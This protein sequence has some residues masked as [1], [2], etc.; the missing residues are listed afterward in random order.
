[1]PK[2]IN[3]LKF[4]MLASLLILM[5]TAESDPAALG[6]ALTLLIMTSALGPRNPLGPFAIGTGLVSLAE[7]YAVTA[8][9]DL[10]QQ[11]EDSL[12]SS[13]DRALVI[14]KT[15]HEYLHNLKVFKTQLDAGRLKIPQAQSRALQKFT[16]ESIASFETL[17]AYH[18]ELLIN[19]QN[20]ISHSREDSSSFISIAK[21]LTAELDESHAQILH[22][23]AYIE[24][25][26]Q[27]HFT[28]LQ[29]EFA[30]FRHTVNDA[31][32]KPTAKS[33]G[34]L[35]S[36]FILT[37]L[38]YAIV[39][40]N[41]GK[42]II[43]PYFRRQPPPQAEAAPEVH[44]RQ[45][46]TTAAPNI[47]LHPVQ[48]PVANPLLPGKAEEERAA[49]AKIKAEESKIKREALEA[50]QAARKAAKEARLQEIRKNRE[51]AIAKERQLVAQLR[52]KYEQ[53]KGM[54]KELACG[55]YYAVLSLEKEIN[56][57]KKYA[58]KTTVLEE[59]IHKGTS[60]NWIN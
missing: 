24:E 55:W 52:E 3:L 2:K 49:E 26:A 16:D 47:G 57:S 34:V 23:Q 17:L 32:P 60:N 28:N 9:S 45:R 46:R 35:P 8:P 48:E 18:A 22:E 33:E 4:S 6:S 25:T 12:H 54:K 40:F 42:Y 7:A 19:T 59:C 10:K 41:V 53:L 15:S 37:T 27:T 5:M 30:V 13:L 1:M 29:E 50:E 51:A 31:A 56:N 38:I 44:P 20:L 36:F 11:A 21:Q 58:G 14:E 39:G 43:R